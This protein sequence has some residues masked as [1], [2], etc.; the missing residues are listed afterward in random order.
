[1]G[2]MKIKV[3]P[4]GAKLI[5]TGGDLDVDLHP[6]HGYVR[7]IHNVIVS[8]EHPDENH[9]EVVQHHEI[10]HEE[11]EEENSGHHG[12]H[13]SYH[14]DEHGG[15]DDEGYGFRHFHHWPN[16]LD[17]EH[18]FLGHDF[19]HDNHGHGGDH[20]GHFRDEIN[21]AKEADHHYEDEGGHSRHKIT[22]EWN[23]DIGRASNDDVT[24][25]SRDRTFYRTIDNSRND[26]V[27]YGSMCKQC[28]I[29]S[30]SSDCSSSFFSFIVC[31]FFSPSFVSFDPIVLLKPHSNHSLS[32]CNQSSSQRVSE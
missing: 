12:W 11:G 10:E 7:P 5:F 28:F 13:H 19:Y 6:A 9:H 27:I 22:G 20:H 25:Q 17:G 1:M 18:S 26:A 15:H 14:H 24:G 21:D 32:P 2:K 23:D 4:E 3:K 8:H 31:L 16:S 30:N 29:S